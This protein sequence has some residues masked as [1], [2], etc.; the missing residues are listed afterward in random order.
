MVDVLFAKCFLFSNVDLKQRL[1]RVV[2]IVFKGF[3]KGGACFW[4]VPRQK[5]E[6]AQIWVVFVCS[7]DSAFPK[8]IGNTYYEPPIINKGGYTALR[9]FLKAEKAKALRT[10]RRADKRT[11]GRTLF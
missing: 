3:Q 7:V 11:D 2:Q 9:R 6:F 8:N 4:A 10:D 1:V 5:F